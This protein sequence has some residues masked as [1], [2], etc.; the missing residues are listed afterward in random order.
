LISEDKSGPD[1]E[2]KEKHFNHA[3]IYPDESKMVLTEN[4]VVICSK[5]GK[6]SGEK[7]TLYKHSNQVVLETAEDSERCQVVCLN[8][9]MGRGLQRRKQNKLCQNIFPLRLRNW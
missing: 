7:I 3:H 6:F 8:A 1:P 5:Q 2:K 9:L 4:P